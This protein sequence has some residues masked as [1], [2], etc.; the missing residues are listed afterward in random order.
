MRQTP[1]TPK[2][3]QGDQKTFC[4]Y[5]DCTEKGLSDLLLFL[6]ETEVNPNERFGPVLFNYFIC[7]CNLGKKTFESHT[8][9]K[10]VLMLEN[11]TKPVYE[12]KKFT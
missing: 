1:L 4:L 3:Y 7:L 9:L 5:L 6:S 8:P 12:G 10:Y 2:E 11:F